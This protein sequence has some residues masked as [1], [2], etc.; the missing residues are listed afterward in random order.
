MQRA[1]PP[2]FRRHQRPIVLIAAA[3]FVCFARLGAAP[4]WVLNEAREGL[5]ARAMLATGDFV[6]PNVPNHVE[7]GATI[8]DKPPLLHWLDGGERWARSLLGGQA[9]SGRALAQA[10]D[11]FDLRF[12]SA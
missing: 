3:L 11:V 2:W 4:I 6:L 8:P 7:N 9:T 1:A 10:F 5:Y 12:G